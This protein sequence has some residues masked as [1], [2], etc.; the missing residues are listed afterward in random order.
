MKIE[1]E[2]DHERKNIHEELDE[3]MDEM[4]TDSPTKKKVAFEGS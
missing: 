1:F 2:E 3:L 4:P